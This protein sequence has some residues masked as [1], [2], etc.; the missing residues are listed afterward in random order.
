MLRGL[1]PFHRGHEHPLFLVSD[2]TA[3]DLVV[4]IT[5]FGLAAID[6]EIVEQVIMPRAPPDLGVHDDRAIQPDHLVGRGAPA[7]TDSSS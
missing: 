1:L 6:H 3:A 4:A 2:P 7:G 5:L